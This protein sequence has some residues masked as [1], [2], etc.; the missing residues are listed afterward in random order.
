MESQTIGGGDKK[1]F[2]P[3]CQGIHKDKK[4]PLDSTQPSEWSTPVRSQ[5][6]LSQELEEDAPDGNQQAS[7]D[8]EEDNQPPVHDISDEE[9]NA[10]DSPESWS[11]S[12]PSKI[13]EYILRP[14]TRKPH[15]HDPTHQAHDP[16]PQAHASTPQA[17]ASTPQANASTPQANA[18]TPQANASTPQANASTPQANASTPQANASTPQANAS[19]PQ[20]NASTPQANASTPQA[21]ASTP[22]AHDPTPALTLPKS[23][24]RPHS[25]RHER[26]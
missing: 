1:L 13:G 3:A 11:S 7:S 5:P 4:S 18:S 9:V 12:L 17:N 10:P 6:Q 14:I 22:Q 20:A 21:N 2:K 19:T 15:A 26:A 24:P 25:T 16:T 23:R 8:E